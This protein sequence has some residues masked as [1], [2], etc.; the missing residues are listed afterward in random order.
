VSFDLDA[1]LAQANALGASDLHVKVPSRPRARIGGVLKPLPD[2]APVTPADTELLMHQV[3]ATE[4]KREQYD[5]RGAVE[6]SYYTHEARFRASVFS[7]RGSVALIFRLI[8][9]APTPE[10]LGI[11]ET[12]LGWSQAKQGLVIVGGPTGS[13]KSTTSAVVIR[14]INEA[15][16][17]H[18]VTIEDPIEYLHPDNEA[19]VS[20]REIGVD[21][22]NFHDALRSALRQDPDV[23]LVGEVR[24]EETAMT[25]LR[26]AETGHLVFCTIHT[27]GAAESIQR[28]VELFGERNEHVARELVASSLVGVVSQRLIPA[29]GGNLALNPDVLVATGRVRDMLRDAAPASA[30]QEAMVEGSYYG[31]QT[32]DQDLA[33]KVRAAVIDEKTA[34]AYAT[35]LQDF[36]LM[37]QGSLITRAAAGASSLSFMHPEQDDAPPPGV[38]LDERQ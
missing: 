29:P 1:A 33:E 26:A 5:Q 22:P 3:L 30:L 35:N 8:T 7:Q 34:L 25:A 9:E 38:P 6:V 37:L 27:S 23:I 13:G 24:D 11:P 32:F 12:V 20:Q 19:L 21:A 18:I 17:C 16:P 28:F 4:A 2:S 15:R 36:K 31:M 14:L 10:G